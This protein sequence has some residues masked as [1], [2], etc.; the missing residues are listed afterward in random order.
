MHACL[1]HEKR[2]FFQIQITSTDSW[3]NFVFHN[4]ITIL[5]LERFDRKKDPNSFRQGHIRRIKHRHSVRIAEPAVTI[6]SLNDTSPDSSNDSMK[7]YRYV[8]EHCVSKYFLCTDHPSAADSK[9]VKIILL[10]SF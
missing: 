4:L 9:L 8:S 1:T 6:A 5:S 7:V 3:S 2:F 10:L